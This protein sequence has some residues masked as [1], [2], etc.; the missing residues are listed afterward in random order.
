MSR[1]N[2]SAPSSWTDQPSSSTPG[3]PSS[4]GPGPGHGPAE[5]KLT[6]QEVE[7]LRAV[8]R[9][10]DRYKTAGWF[11]GG[12]AS[13][14]FLH[15][16]KPRPSNLQIATLSFVAGL[17]CSFLMIP[18]GII[19]SKDAIFKVDDPN[20]LKRVLSGAMED[21]RRGKTPA[22]GVSPPKG[23]DGEQDWAS[24]Q[25]R[26]AGS[27]KSNSSPDRSDDKILII[28]LFFFVQTRMDSRPPVPMTAHSLA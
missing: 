18:L 20:H 3:P 17:G 27:S 5:G 16:R 23:L 11:L 28:F 1:A 2:Q 6:P 26:L 9:S 7:A 8:K 25:S 21:H 4:G 12:G 22:I 24:N 19:N 15:R 10:V 14:L 13:F